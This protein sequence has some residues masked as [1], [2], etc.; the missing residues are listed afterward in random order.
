MTHAMP[1]LRLLSP[2]DGNRILYR[3]ARFTLA[4]C[5]GA[6]LFLAGSLAGYCQSPP[7]P[8][9]PSAPDN[10]ASSPA[11]ASPSTPASVPPPAATSSEDEQ[12]LPGDWGPELL[13]GILNSSN[14]DAQASL[15]RA[16]FAAGPAVIPQLVEALKDDRT[17]EFAA[18]ALAYI[19]GE[20][21]LPALEKL[22]T[23]PRDLSLRRFTYG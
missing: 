15:M 22:L 6:V 1:A 5:L 20:H 21:A 13:Y 16:T 23:D 10:S 2:G 7:A 17:A 12:P 11:Q 4:V 3:A 18:Q 19:G 9:S 8:S 14:E